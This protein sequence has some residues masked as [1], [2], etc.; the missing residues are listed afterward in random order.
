MGMPQ[1]MGF[2]LAAG[3]TLLG[4]SVADLSDRA[5]VTIAMIKRAE[6]SPGE[7]DV[8]TAKLAAIC[9]TL[10]GAGVVFTRDLSRV[11]VALDLRKR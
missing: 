11:G 8:P 6:A 9:A 1:V 5:G 7:A 3:R 4:W 10:Y 2:Q